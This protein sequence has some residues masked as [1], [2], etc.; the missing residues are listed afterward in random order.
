[1]QAPSQQPAAGSGGGQPTSGIAASKELARVT[2]SKRP[3]DPVTED[4]T[5]HSYVAVAPDK[6]ART[7]KPTIESGAAQAHMQPFRGLADGQTAKSTD[8]AVGAAHALSGLTPAEGV[9]RERE[10]PLYVLLK[11]VC[12]LEQSKSGDSSCASDITC[13]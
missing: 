3:N 1:M 6:R 9:V 4:A 7:E 11:T 5:V 13:F 8:S 2:S 12:S 10:M